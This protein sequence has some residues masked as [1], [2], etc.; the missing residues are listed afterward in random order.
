MW[1]RDVGADCG[2]RGR[3]AGG[4]EQRY[5]GKPDGIA[6]TPKERQQDYKTTRLQVD[7]VQNV[8]E[9]A[10][11]D[12]NSRLY[13][14]FFI[15]FILSYGGYFI[16]KSILFEDFKTARLLLNAKKLSCE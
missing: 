11:T 13:I 10:L 8:K 12:Q 9:D 7:K 2:M 1:G 6:G 4:G 14:I 3:D 15:K 5:S 16:M